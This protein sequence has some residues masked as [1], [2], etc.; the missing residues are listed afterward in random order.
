MQCKLQATT[1]LVLNCEGLG[2]VCMFDIFHVTFNFKSKVSCDVFKK[3]ECQSTSTFSSKILLQCHMLSNM[4]H[5]IFLKCQLTCD[6]FLDK[7][8]CM[9]KFKLCMSINV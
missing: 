8:H 9:S 4:C 1:R 7:S 5:F 6:F 2:A 3:N